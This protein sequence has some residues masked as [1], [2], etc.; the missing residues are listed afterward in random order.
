MTILYISKHISMELDA[1]SDA[2]YHE[3]LR[4]GLAKALTLKNKALQGELTRAI[5]AAK[6]KRRKASRR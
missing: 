6:L 5:E 3:A 1:L 4:Q 2:T